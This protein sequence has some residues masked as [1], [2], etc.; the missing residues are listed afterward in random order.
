MNEES[1]ARLVSAGST[2]DEGSPAEAREA[3][4]S[5]SPAVELAD[6]EPEDSDDDAAFDFSAHR[7]QAIEAYQ[8]V[9]GL[10]VDCAGA[11]RSVLKT[12]LGLEEVSVLSIEARGKRVDSFADKASS[13]SEE[14]PTRPKYSDPLNEIT[15]LSGVRVI[16]YLLDPVKRT[17]GIVEREFEI[18]EKVQRTGLLERNERL[19]Y[20]SF[21]FLVK[22]T[23]DRLGLPEYAR[24][25]NI[26][27]EIQVRTIL[28][29][30]WA[31]IEHDIQ[32]KAVET[33][34]TSIRR[35]FTSLAGLVEI[36]DRDFR[37]SQMRTAGCDKMRDVWFEQV[38][39][40]AWKLRQTR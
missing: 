35:R 40:I 11:V 3:P 38:P 10:Y 19:G 34:P 25:R 20:Q 15:D 8:P 18:I 29:H 28:Q 39:S 27:T 13:P 22:F 17:N 6:A 16:T 4:Q 21:H 9:R 30:A 36:A 33:I 23:E 7:R 12:T 37:P 26:I 32:Y 5:T 24:F 1:E 31:E 14:D 2:E